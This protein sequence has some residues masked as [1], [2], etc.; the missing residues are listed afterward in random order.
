M[1]GRPQ[2]HADN[3]EA[4][5]LWRAACT[6]WRATGFGVVG[7]DYPA[8]FAVADI[9]DVDVTP[10]VLELVQGLERFELQRAS[11]RNETT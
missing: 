9:V 1:D 10:R 6:Q 4:Y 3:A 7:L 8:L 5:R 2:L 11:E